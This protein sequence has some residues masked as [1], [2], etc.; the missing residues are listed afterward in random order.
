MGGLCKELETLSNLLSYSEMII[1]GQVQILEKAVCDQL[2]VII[3]DTSMNP[4][5]AYQI[6]LKL[7]PQIDIR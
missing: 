2:P 3:L 1:L 7:D 4:C 5:V 6:F